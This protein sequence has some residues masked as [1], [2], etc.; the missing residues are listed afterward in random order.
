MVF[1]NYFFSK[2]TK[3]KLGSQL[4]FVLKNIKNPKGLFGSYF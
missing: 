3:N 2:K 4:F 1:E